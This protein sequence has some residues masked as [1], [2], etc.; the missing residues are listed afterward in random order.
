MLPLG[1]G[2][3][4]A[5]L[6]GA[7]GAAAG[8]GAGWAGGFAAGAGAA[9]AAAGA[10]GGATGGGAGG[11][12]ARSRLVRAVN[13]MTVVAARQVGRRGGEIRISVVTLCIPLVLLFSPQWMPSKPTSSLRFISRGPDD[14]PTDLL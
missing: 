3:V 12:Q 10:L 6:A 9:G 14:L 4:A 11:A 1:S 5:G 2:G 7:A 13:E 8:A